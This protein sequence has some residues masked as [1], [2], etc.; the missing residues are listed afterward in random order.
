MSQW[1]HVSGVIR[2]DG[3]PAM[4]IVPNL[5]SLLGSPSSDDYERP[6]SNIPSGSEGSIQYRVLTVGKGL[7]FQTVAIWG[8]LRDFGESDSSEID[9]WFEKIVGAARKENIRKS[10]LML[11]AAHLLVEVEG[12]I[13]YLLVLNEDNDDKIIQRIE[14]ERVAV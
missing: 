1:T 4:G 5:E 6:A 10:C 3:I 12:G 9:A 11:R 8:D 13:R 14:L 7:V 2:V